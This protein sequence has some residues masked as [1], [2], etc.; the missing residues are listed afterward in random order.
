MRSANRTKLRVTGV[1]LALA[2][3]ALI[4]AACGGTSSPGVASLGSTTSTTIAGG[5]A[6]SGRSGPTRAQLLTY[7]ECMRAHG[8]SDFPDPVPSPLG[9][10]G[11]H[12]HITPG[13]D[14]DPNT[15]KH[16][17]AEKACQK[18]VPSSIANLT[19]ATMAANAL[20]WS[21]CMRTHGEPN[22]PEPN[23][24]GMITLNVD[25]NSPQFQKAEKACQKLGGDGFDIQNTYGSG[26]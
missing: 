26:G 17:S 6:G 2:A 18:D 5:V 3:V 24:Q 16:Q 1:G 21:K 13:S 11:F 15:P 12:Y 22:F 10:F 19:P 8:L 14:L 9:G 7:A 25:P 23:G 20:K 4:F